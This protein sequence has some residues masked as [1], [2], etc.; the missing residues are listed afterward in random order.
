MDLKGLIF[1]N[2]QF[3]RMWWFR[4]DWFEILFTL[5]GCCGIVW[6]DFG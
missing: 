2:I 6:V 3:G 4:K 5:G 1:N